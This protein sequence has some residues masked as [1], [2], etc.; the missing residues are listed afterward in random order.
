M[1]RLSLTLV[2]FLA[3]LTILAADDLRTWSDAS[4]KYTIEAKFITLEG[5]KVI[6]EKEDG[7]RIQIELNK[8]KP[9]DRSEA[10]KLHSKKLSGDANNPFKEAGKTAG[11][12]RNNRK[13]GSKT[14]PEAD[15]NVPAQ[16][17]IDWAGV[18]QLSVFGS[19]WKE[20][21]TIPVSLK[22]DWQP[23]PVAIPSADFWD[24]PT[25]VVASATAKRAVVVS[26]FDKPGN[27][28][29]ATST[30]HLCDLEKGNIVKSF[31]VSGK[32]TPL[33]ISADGTQVVARQDIFGHNKSNVLELWKI[34]D[35]DLVRQHRWEASKEENNHG[36]DVHGATFLSDGK[37]FLTW[38]SG[39]MLTWWNADSLKPI[40]SLQLQGNTS[41]ALS[42][43]Q[44]FIVGK[45]NTDLVLLD[46]ATGETLGVKPLGHGTHGRFAISPDGR[47]LAVQNANKVEIYELPT[48]SLV[49]SISANGFGHESPLYWTS[50]MTLMGG[51]P[52]SY[53]APDMNVNV[54]AYDGI[55]KAAFLGDYTLMIA[56]GNGGKGSTLVPAKLP[57]SAA[58]QLLEQARTDPNFFVLKPGATVRVDASGISDSTL[59]Q[60]AIEALTRKLEETGFKVGSGGPTLVAGLEKSKDHEVSYHMFGP[61]F[62]RDKTHTVPGW[63]YTLKLVADGR[64]QWSTGG[65]NHPPHFIQLKKD[66]TIESHLKQYGTP[67]ANFFK[68]VE[69]PKYVARAL[70]DQPQGSTSLKRSQV[71]SNGI[72]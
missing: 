36:K 7:S 24:K 64:T 48:A 10:L 5:G 47:L 43:D 39:G 63:T 52:L 4:G 2:V 6:L 54:W 53:L 29:S 11:T 28:D 19:D 71:T 49:T 55:E 61:G 33:A 17:N 18:K 67:N 45:S 50:P 58:V 21:N 38:L 57:H 20:Q 22:L 46:A 15:P 8:L 66:E 12:G 68:H 51:Q 41:P 70:S 65:G 27:K 9:E 37:T 72:R 62:G 26:G 69:L 56:G 14:T 60:E 13:T 30:V 40:Q 3:C 25:G 42:P 34:T 35:S 59:Q 1:H 16:A 32:F 23:R 31:P 44:K